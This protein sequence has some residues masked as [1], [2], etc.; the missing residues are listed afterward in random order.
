MILENIELIPR[1]EKILTNTLLLD[2][3]NPR[4]EFMVE[5]LKLTTDDEY[6]KQMATVPDINGLKQSIFSMG[7]LTDA[8]V[9]VDLKNGFYLVLDGNSRTWCIRELFNANPDVDTFK[10]VD[11]QIYTDLTERQILLI[12]AGAHVGG[13]KEW[14]KFA[15]V[16]NVKLMLKKG[17]NE[18]FLQTFLQTKSIADDIEAYDLCMQYIDFFNDPT[19]TDK[20]S[21]FIEFLTGKNKKLV[22]KCRTDPKFLAF[23]FKMIH[24]GHLPRPRCMKDIT[25]IMNHPGAKHALEAHGYEEALTELRRSKPVKNPIIKAIRSATT[26]IALFGYS[27]V[28]EFKTLPDKASRERYDAIVELKLAIRRLEKEA[29]MQFNIRNTIKKP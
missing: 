22:K 1:R 17:I 18:P 28:T 19:G 29:D 16:R 13:S 15:K 23:F 8:L 9:V 5:R 4:I 2:N 20:I 6:H 10:Y 12:R 25:A 14:I 3:E 26:Q 11:V 27:E 24:N 21:I 7:G